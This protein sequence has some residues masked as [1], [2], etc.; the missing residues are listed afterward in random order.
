MV[1]TAS[2]AS[3]VLVQRCVQ[4]FL[5][6][7]KLYCGCEAHAAR[8]DHWQPRVSAV[9]VGVFLVRTMYVVSLFTPTKTLRGSV[10]FRVHI[11]WE[12]NPAQHQKV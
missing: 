4:V 5:G 8:F 10:I 1:H 7:S 12:I 11:C 3:P 6:I 9:N 2:Q